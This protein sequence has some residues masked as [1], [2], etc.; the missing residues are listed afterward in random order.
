MSQHFG[1]TVWP[2]VLAIDS[3]MDRL[4]V[5]KSLRIA[6]KRVVAW[7]RLQ[8][9]NLVGGIEPSISTPSQ[10]RVEVPYR[11]SRVV[12]RGMKSTGYR[13]S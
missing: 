9:R 10:D 1:R 8:A 6:F 11:R 7:V 3:K 5:R 12:V 13:G 4:R 2:R